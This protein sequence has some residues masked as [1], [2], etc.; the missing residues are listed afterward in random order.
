MTDVPNEE[1]A[2]VLDYLQ[3]GKAASVRSEP[4]V[5]LLGTTFFTL[6]EAV[7]KRSLSIQEKVYI[8]REER[9]DIS[10]IKGRIRFPQLTTT[11]Q[12]E[13]E[14]AIEK[15]IHAEPDR[16]LDFFNKSGSL[17]LKQH[18]LELLPGMGRKHYQLVIDERNKKP[19]AS[20]AELEERLKMSP[21]P[22]KMLAKRVVEELEAEGQKYFLFAR[23]PAREDDRRHDGGFRG[24]R[25]ESDR[26]SRPY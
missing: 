10:M 21:G 12:S 17:S 24:P 6:L 22:V 7:P 26:S 11:A 9:A 18:T 3:H 4:L 23:P 19:F 13:L 1:H 16:F 8:G 14:R 2:I 25:R 5:Q 15:V 20:L